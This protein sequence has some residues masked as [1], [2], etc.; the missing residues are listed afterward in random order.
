MKVYEGEVVKFHAF[1]SSA[2]VHVSD[3]SHAPVGLPSEKELQT[4][5]E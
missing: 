5:H 2:S 4:P 1:L 3:Q